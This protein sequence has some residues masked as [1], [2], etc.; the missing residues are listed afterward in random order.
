VPAHRPHNR[1]ALQTQSRRWSPGIIVTVVVATVVLLGTAC[2]ADPPDAA[3]NDT[4]GLDASQPTSATTWTGCGDRLQCATLEVPVDWDDPDGATIDLAVV[5]RMAT[6]P[7]LGPLLVNPGGPGASGVQ[8]LSATSAFDGLNEQFDLVSWDPR[9]VGDS[10]RLDCGGVGGPDGIEAHRASPI[11][12][13]AA[14]NL[15]LVAEMAGACAL[16]SPELVAN[17]GTDQTVGDMEAIRVA[18]GSEQISFMGFSYGTYLGLAYAERFGPRLRAMVLDG[19]VDPA[20]TLQELLAAQLAGMEPFVDAIT[21]TADGTNLFDQAAA[22]PGVDP[23]VL[24]FAAITATYDPSLPS[25]LRQALT[26]A[27]AGDSTGLR[28]LANRYWS[29]ASFTAYLAT[30]CSD[31]DRPNDLAGYE[32]MANAL[33]ASAPRLGPAVA[34]EVAGCA[35]WPAPP[36]TDDPATPGVDAPQVLVVGATGDLATPLAMAEAVDAA[37]GTSVL[38]IHESGSH[39]SFGRSVCVDTLVIAYLIELAVPADPTSCTS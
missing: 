17:M 6:G 20:L 23:A 1:R 7:S 8:W 36:G 35:W 31:M 39:T 37:L 30:L 9:G 10:T 27:I 28:T 34:G 14:T 4:A 3:P 33:S 21:T 12:A 2:S 24:S 15:D 19:V 22:T 32:A 11:G 29:A 25:V 38:I 16:G 13:E 26:A 18:M 5:R